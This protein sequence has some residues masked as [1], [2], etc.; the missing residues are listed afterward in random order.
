VL[1]LH[2]LVSRF[3]EARSSTIGPDVRT[4]LRH[5]EQ[6]LRRH[7]VSDS[8]IAELCRKYDAWFHVDG[9]YG[10]LFSLCDEGRELLRGIEEADSVALDPH[11]TL[12]LPYGTGAAL[13]REGQ[14]LLDAF[15]ASAEALA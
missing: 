8:E 3:V 15:S 13:V 4:L 14:L 12:F 10:G 11:K 9:A 6:M 1:D 2:P 5:Y 7:I